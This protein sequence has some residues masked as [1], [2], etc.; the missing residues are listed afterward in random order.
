VQYAIKHCIEIQL[1]IIEVNESMIYLLKT[2]DLVNIV[3]LFIYTHMHIVFIVLFSYFNYNQSY[4]ITITA[5]TEYT[6]YSLIAN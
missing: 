2:I 4:T 5:Y 3:Y 1:N 6:L